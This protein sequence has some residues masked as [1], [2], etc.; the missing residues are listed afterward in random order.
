M[1]HA[2]DN[3]SLT[4]VCD[5]ETFSSPEQIL[6]SWRRV[7]CITTTPPRQTI[8]SSFT[9]L[10]S[11]LRQWGTYSIFHLPHKVSRYVQSARKKCMKLTKCKKRFAFQNCFML[12][13]LQ[14]EI[15]SLWTVERPDPMDFPPD[16]TILGP[17]FRPLSGG[18]AC[19]CYF[20]SVMDRVS[21]CGTTLAL[22]CHFLNHFLGA[23]KNSSYS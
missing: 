15:D 18:I 1:L 11:S 10:Q 9:L 4:L 13:S 6:C 14:N 2:R 22:C 5:F 19:F 3:R 7:K 16:M 17:N 21:C 12:E 8:C 23:K 20:L